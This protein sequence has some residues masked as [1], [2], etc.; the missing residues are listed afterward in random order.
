MRAL[1][2][3]GLF[4]IA[5]GLR[6]VPVAPSRG[7]PYWLV[8]LVGSLFV[9]AGVALALPPRATRLGDV[10]AAVI[11]TG[12]AVMA[13]WIG[14]SP[15]ERHSGGTGLSLG[16]VTIQVSDGPSVG[17]IAFTIAG[18]LIALLAV[19]ARRRS[20]RRRDPPVGTGPT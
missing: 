8:S 11:F 20:F 18:A 7:V 1:V 4:I 6:V 3:F 14:A 17:R 13:L 19:L 9:L 2:A 12:F 15:G 10:I 5:V 16:P